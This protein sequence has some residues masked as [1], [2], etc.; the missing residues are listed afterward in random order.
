M[1]QIMQLEK[2]SNKCGTAGKGESQRLTFTKLHRR[3]THSLI[4][5]DMQR[6]YFD[7]ETF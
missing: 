7:A 5:F 6:I 2:L 1:V 4:F 3:R